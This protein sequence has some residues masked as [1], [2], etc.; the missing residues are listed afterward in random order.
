MATIWVNE[1][2]D[3]TGIVYAW[4]ITMPAAALIA[5]LFY[6]LATLFAG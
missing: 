1:Q 6:G 4:V 2:L 5:A 3:P